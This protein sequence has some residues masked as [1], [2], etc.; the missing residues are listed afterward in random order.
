MI[1]ALFS[2]LPFVKGR[3]QAPILG[4]LL[5]H[6]N[7]FELVFGSY[8]RFHHGFMEAAVVTGDWPLIMR[9]YERG[10]R[11]TSQCLELAASTGDLDLLKHVHDKLERP[12]LDGNVELPAAA[13][14]SNN[15]EMLTWAMSRSAVVTSICIDHA[16]ENGNQEILEL[17]VESIALVEADSLRSIAKANYA[18]IFMRVHTKAQQDRYSSCR[19]YLKCAVDNDNKQFAVVLLR[20]GYKPAQKERWQLRA[21]WPE[22]DW[23]A[24]EKECGDYL[25]VMRARKRKR[26]R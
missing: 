12:A 21:K 3:K 14:K 15:L 1:T 4:L 5:D 9:A 11:F 22:E 17:V 7:D 18:D 2:M 10:F 19:N 6:F 13:C 26:K 25:D 8:S 20:N 24:L 23:G 16:A